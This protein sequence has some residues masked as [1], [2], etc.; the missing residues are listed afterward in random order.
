MSRPITRT[1]FFSFF[2]LFSSYSL[3]YFYGSSF[4][5]SRQP[6]QQT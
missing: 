1:Y 5:A 3:M 6:L 2:F 4:K